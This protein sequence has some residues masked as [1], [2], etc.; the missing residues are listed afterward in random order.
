MFSGTPIQDSIVSRVP[1]FS[2]SSQKKRIKSKCGGLYLVSDAR[3][4]GPEIEVEKSW[5]KDRG[6]ESQVRDV[7]GTQTS[8]KGGPDLVTQKPKLGPKQCLEGRRT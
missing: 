8:K 6:G 1:R 4:G 2:G 5:F 3:K 7:E